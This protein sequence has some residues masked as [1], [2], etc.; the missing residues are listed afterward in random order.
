MTFVVQVAADLYVIRKAMYGTDLKATVSKIDGQLGNRVSRGQA[1]GQPIGMI[2]SPIVRPWP[3]SVRLSV[4]ETVS[5]KGSIDDNVVAQSIAY[6]NWNRGHVLLVQ[7]SQ[8][9]TNNPRV[10]A[11]AKMVVHYALITYLLAIQFQFVGN[12]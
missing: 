9:P 2:L 6:T 4:S 8:D 1:N 5:R 10:V 11:R 7:P 12:R 3:D